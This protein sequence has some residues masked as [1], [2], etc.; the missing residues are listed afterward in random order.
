[1]RR[2]I[3]LLAC[4]LA[5]GLAAGAWAQ[6]DKLPKKYTET[7][8]TQSGEK[9]SFDMTLIPGGTFTM[10][11][12]ADEEGR[13]DH[14]GPQH[15]VKLDK[16]YLGTTEMTLDLFMAYYQETGTAKKDFIETAESTKKAEEEKNEANVNAISG[17]TPVYGDMSM[18]YSKKHPAIGLTWHNAMTFCKWLSQKTGKEYR[19]PTEAE[20]EYAARAGST[21][22]YGS[23]ENADQLK[24]YACYQDNS[25]FCPQ[26]VGNTKPNAFGL[27]D[28]LG[29]VS[30]W[31]WD[32]YDPTAY[33]KQAQ[34]GVAV[35]PT[36]PKEGEVH[37]ARGGFYDSALEEV[38]CAARGF[39]EKWWR[40]NDPQIPK[41]I[42]WLP[43][44]DV[45]GFRVACTVKPADDK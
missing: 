21:S 42:W 17:P 28:M 19:L 38:R 27:Y 5:V 45:V 37:V 30:E 35:N 11:S 40:M 15:K 8:T 34:Q 25:D 32:F 24:D 2:R 18:G 23:C 1:M 12:P 43:Q 22:M 16:F 41:S 3:I 13:A 39:E 26:A 29:N 33:A 9:L 31:V 7:M 4:C 44:I 36:G 20:W 10:G 6:Q 14:E